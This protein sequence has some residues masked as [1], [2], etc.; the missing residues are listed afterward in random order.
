MPNLYD[1]AYTLGLGFSAPFWLAVPK[2]RLKVL[3]ALRERMGQVETR[4][5]SQWAVM[6]HAVSLGE[7]NATQSLVDRLRKTEPPLQ[8]IISTTTDTGYARGGQL[9]G[10]APDV[11]L[12]KYPLDFSRGI[13]R[14]LDRLQPALVVLME[15]EVWPNFLR[16][17]ER[18][19]IPV[20]VAN[21]RM[22]DSSYRNYQWIKPVV[23]S[24][25]RRLKRICAQDD[26]YAKRFMELGAP[27][28]SVVVAGALKFDT[29]QLADRIP[30][31]EELATAVGVY[32]GVEP[33]W[34]C[35]STG[36]GEEQIVLR[37][38]RQLLA[39]NA[40]LRL[41]IVPRKPE[42][43]DE[44][45][46]LI[47][48]MKFQL[49]RRSKPASPIQRG[50]LPPIVLGDTM[51]ELRNFYSLADLVFVGRSLVDLGSKQHG[52]DMIEPAALGRPVIVGPH[53]G[54][55]TDVMRRF[56]EA[57]A[58]RIVHDEDQLRDA[59]TELLASPQTALA[60]GKR[61]REVVRRGQGATE[62]HVKVIL[63]VLDKV[64]K[65]SWPAIVK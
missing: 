45:A 63:D 17:C 12:I 50:V 22:S 57:D 11:R 62:R 6:I 51:G 47:E 55:F 2:A 19:G 60:M 10:N 52:S 35:G 48:S 40:R 43:F 18:R 4:N 56:I 31:D 30:G 58:M 42:R 14:V 26:A 20:I 39:N 16:Q 34:V 28:E 27:P 24:M 65:T 32:P 38:Y 3:R 21:G 33:I 9:Y 1:I 49:I 37:I 64:E 44:V 13:S 5:P 53:T 8:F 7:M 36:P 59:L 23:A 54:N 25:F 41:V 15:L 61:S 46:A 29:A